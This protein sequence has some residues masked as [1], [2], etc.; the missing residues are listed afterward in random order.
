MADG[1]DLII[2]GGTIVDGTGRPGVDG[3]IAIRDGQIVAVGKVAGSAREEID[4]SGRLVTPG[5]VDIHTHY[6]G[7][8]TWANRLNPSS[9]HGV[10]TVVLGNCGVG[11]APCKPDDRERLVHLMEGVEDI[12]EVVM[13]AG[14]PWNWVSFPDY[15]DSL[16]TRRFDMDVATQLPHA[17]LRVFVMGERAMTKEPA[18][19]ADIAQMRAIAKEAVE[20]GALGF[21]TSRSLNHRAADGTVTPSY[22]AAADEL[23]GIAR[24]L[25]EAGK[26]VLQFISDFDDIDPEFDIAR[27]MTIESG[28]PLSMSLIQYHHAPERWRSVLEHINA[29]NENGLPIKGQVSGRPIATLHG[30]RLSRN[31]FMVAA[32]F[33]ELADLPEDDRI[34]ELRRPERRARILAEYAGAAGANPKRSAD[35]SNL[36]EF[37]RASGYEPTPDLSMTARAEAAAQDAAAFT[38]DLLLAGNAEAVLYM[39]SANYYA[40][41]NE[42]IRTMLE[43]PHTLLGLGDGGAHVGLI[44]DA[45]LPTYMIQR[46][47]V[48]GKGDMPI[49]RV[50][51]ALT[52]ANAAAVGLTDRGVIAPGY[53]ADI[54]VIDPTN[55]GI[56]RPEIIRDLPNGAGRLGQPATGYDATIV[57]GEVTYRGGVATGALPGRLVRGS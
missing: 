6:D 49:E 30:F 45:S 43:S 12:P 46:W 37:G 9:Q 50:I 35:L 11:F 57:A 47:S 10:T 55:V 51:A 42:A 22:A 3:D 40:N 1:F 25:G 27:R 24:G 15:L 32:G 41:S 21:S 4:A 16:E 53:R 48:L 20:A 19:A 52:S 29:A 23:A 39:P 56:L 34:A 13:T 36:Y 31:P 33:E 28:R 7:H 18:T 54:N 17:P 26:G 8:V 2:R 14:L 44:C 38:Y 5:F